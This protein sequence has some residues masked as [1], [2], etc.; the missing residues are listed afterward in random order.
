M[1]DDTSPSSS[2]VTLHLAMFIP[3]AIHFSD[4][5][6]FQTH[7]STPVVTRAH[8]PAT[9][10]VQHTTPHSF[11]PCFAGRKVYIFSQYISTDTKY[12]KHALNLV[13]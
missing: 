4:T 8:E 2:L 9:L 5:L 7:K 6:K 3:F 1:D 12:N 10:L 11:L 13:R